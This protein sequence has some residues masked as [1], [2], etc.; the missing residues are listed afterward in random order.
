MTVMLRRAELGVLMASLV[1]AGV[2]LPRGLPASPCGPGPTQTATATPRTTVWPKLV[3]LSASSFYRLR[4]QLRDA[5][6]LDWQVRVGTTNAYHLSPPPA[7][8][9]GVDLFD[10][11]EP[12]AAV[13]GVEYLPPAWEQGPPP[14]A[15]QED[16][17][18]FSWGTPCTPAGRS[19]QTSDHSKWTR[20]EK[21]RARLT[22]SRCALTC[23]SRSRRPS[24]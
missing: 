19:E 6:F 9:Q 18:L 10:D 4:H 12:P 22:P 7:E 2:P 24:P 15:Q 16:P 3:P 14:A 21:H 13:Q 5:G 1:E 17:L 8:E 11:P 20:Q 23:P